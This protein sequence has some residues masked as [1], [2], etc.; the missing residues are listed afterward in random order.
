[1]TTI[2]DATVWLNFA[3]VDSVERLIA[4]LPGRLAVGLLVETEVRFWP[5]GSALAGQAFSLED[6]VRRGLLERAEM[7]P[8]EMAAFHATKVGMRLGDGETEALVI[9]ARRGWLVATDDGPARKKLATHQPPV[10]LSGTI[11]LLREL[12]QGKA[13]KRRE[14][15][16]LLALMR[17]RGARLPDEEI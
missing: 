11:G 15:S 12:V 1:M 5:R 16:E 13:V 4:G 17:H 10:M 14:A 2:L 8:G 9:A 6:F 7:T 3:R